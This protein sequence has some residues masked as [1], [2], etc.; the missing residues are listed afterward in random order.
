MPDQVGH[1]G[2]VVGHDGWRLGITALW[3]KPHVVIPVHT[4]IHGCPIRSGMTGLWSGITPKR[5]RT[6]SGARLG[7]VVNRPEPFDDS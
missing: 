2:L 7:S 3:R 1:D 4:G 5:R 6:A